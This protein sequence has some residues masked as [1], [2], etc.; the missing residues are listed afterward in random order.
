M[1]LIPLYY[2]LDKECNIVVYNKNTRKIQENGCY[3]TVAMGYNILVIHHLCMY[4]VYFYAK[5]E[6][7]IYNIN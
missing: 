4:Y 2:S 6:R 3:A 5:Y 1:Y 7:Y